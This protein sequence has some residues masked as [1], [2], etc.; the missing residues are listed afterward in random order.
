MKFDSKEYYPD[1]NIDV[2]NIL[3]EKGP[4]LNWVYY[5]YEVDFF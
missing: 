5:T 2:L 1:K 3:I 4:N